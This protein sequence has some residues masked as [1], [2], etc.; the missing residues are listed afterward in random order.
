MGTLD[1]YK[2]RQSEA[3]QAAGAASADTTQ[4]TQ[5][6]SSGGTLE[7][8]QRKQAEQDNGQDDTIQLKNLTPIDNEIPQ[9]PSRRQ[10]LSD[11][12]A[13]Q[14]QSHIDLHVA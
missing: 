10:K 4:D 8:W 3:R 1:R 2:K 9:S 12:H 6:S 13:H 5:G 11:D 14:A 7:R